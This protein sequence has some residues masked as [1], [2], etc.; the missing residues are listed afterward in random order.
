VRRNSEVHRKAAYPD[1][2]LRQSNRNGYTLIEVGVVVTLLAFIIGS[3]TLRTGPSIKKARNQNSLETLLLAERQARDACRRSRRQGNLRYS[4]QNQTL[5]FELEQTAIG[6]IS[7]PPSLELVSVRTANGENA[8]LFVGATGETE[9]YV[10]SFTDN[11]QPRSILVAGVTGKAIP[12]ESSQDA[13][14]IF[15]TLQP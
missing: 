6:T 5:T 2:P 9:S 12:L 8:N 10:L 4:L 3:V 13:A 14:S 11:D 1:S 7:L 15:A